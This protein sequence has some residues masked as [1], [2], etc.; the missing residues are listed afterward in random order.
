MKSKNSTWTARKIVNDKPVPFIAMTIITT[1]VL[2]VFGD[3]ALTQLLNIN[4]QSIYTY[5]YSL[6][7]YG[8]VFVIPSALF[9]I[10]TLKVWVR[11]K[12]SVIPAK[13]DQT[14]SMKNSDHAEQRSRY[15]LFLKKTGG[16]LWTVSK[17]T[18]LGLFYFV[19][20]F[21]DYLSSG[22]NRTGSN[23]SSSSH[24]SNVT[25]QRKLKDDAKW[26][27]K[28]K[29][30]EA[31]HAVKYAEKQGRYNANTHHYDSKVNS[32]KAKIREANEAHKKARKL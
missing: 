3:K 2:M 19:K 8:L 21:V 20:G 22:L 16:I 18:V 4:N 32:A 11:L 14:N 25:R 6:G 15:T 1:I 12:K 23:R 13:A 5:N 27:A 31:L 17:Y 28:Q 29:R 26:E 24:S 10:A 7:F 9:S 30:K